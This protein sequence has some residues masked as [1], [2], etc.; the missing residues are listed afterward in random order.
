MSSNSQQPPQ[1]SSHHAVTTVICLL[2]D[3]TTGL[4]GLH[5]G[6]NVAALLL[7]CVVGPN[8]PANPQ[9]SSTHRSV[10]LLL[11]CVNNHTPRASTAIWLIAHHDRLVAADAF[12]L[13]SR[14]QEVRVGLKLGGHWR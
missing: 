4:S 9:T 11:C 8:I 7:C 1:T 6:L 12:R 5:A 3:D 14:S 13:E 2:G 10:T